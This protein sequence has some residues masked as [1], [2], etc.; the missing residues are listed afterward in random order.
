MIHIKDLLKRKEKNTEESLGRKILRH[1]LTILYRSVL[2]V[3]VIA[4]AS[5]VF[6]IQMKNRVF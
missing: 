2:V 5:I 4:A 6:V 1:R 3:G